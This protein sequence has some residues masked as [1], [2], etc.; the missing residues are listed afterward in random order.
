VWIKAGTL[1]RLHVEGIIEPGDT[2]EFQ[3]DNVSI[4]PVN[5]P[6]DLEGNTIVVDVAIT[7][8][9]VTPPP[10]SGFG[11]LRKDATDGSVSCVR[12]AWS[13]EASRIDLVNPDDLRKEI[14]RRRAAFRWTDTIRP[15]ATNS[16]YAIQKLTAGG[17]TRAGLA[18]FEAIST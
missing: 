4:G 17:S 9:P 14:V 5:A 12:F 3:L 13:P 15:P 8:R 11:L 7:D 6:T 2:L 16:S 1:Y 18:T 10:E